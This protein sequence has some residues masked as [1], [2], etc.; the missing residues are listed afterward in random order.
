MPSYIFSAADVPITVCDKLDASSRRFWWSPK[1]ESGSFLA[2]KAWDQLCLLKS[3]DGLGFRKAKK[4]NVALLTKLS[5]MVLSNRSSICMRVLRSKYKVRSD[6]LSSEPVKYAS[7][8][9]KAIERL[10]TLISKGVCFLVGDGAIIDI[11]KDPW[12][13]WLQNFVPR[14]KSEIVN[15]RLVV[16]CLINQVSRSWNISKL[17]E[18]FALSLLRLFLKFPFFSLRGLTR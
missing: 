12:D 8:T 4:F 6:W 1:K 18:L 13:P 11:W 5:W 15:E 14:P 2:W 16:A 7:Q 9:W 10:K 17:E 3:I